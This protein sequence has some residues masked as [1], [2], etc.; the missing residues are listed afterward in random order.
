[1]LLVSFCYLSVVMDV[2]YVLYN[3]CIPRSRI[4]L[5]VVVGCLLLLILGD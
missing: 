2:A 1:M 4:G 3:N 5:T